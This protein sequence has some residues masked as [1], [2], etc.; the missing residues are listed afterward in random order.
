MLKT[1]CQ[2]SL[3]GTQLPLF[4]ERPLL[5]ETERWPEIG[6]NGSYRTLRSYWVP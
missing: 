3:S 1:E 4:F 6:E 5:A 2:H